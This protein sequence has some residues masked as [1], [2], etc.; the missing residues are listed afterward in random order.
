MD[1]TNLKQSASANK[2][3]TI[4]VSQLDKINAIPNKITDNILMDGLCQEDQLYLSTLMDEDSS[5]SEDDDHTNPSRRMSSA[6]S[7][8]AQSPMMM[9]NESRTKRLRRMRP[10]YAVTLSLED[11]SYIRP[12]WGL[13]KGVKRIK[14]KRRKEPLG[15][16]SKVTNREQSQETEATQDDEN[17]PQKP[18][19]DQKRLT[20]YHVF[21]VITVTFL[22]TLILLSYFIDLHRYK[23]HIFENRI[24]LDPLARTMEIFRSKQDIFLQED[25]SSFN[26]QRVLG[27]RFGQGIPAN[28]R[29]DHCSCEM[30]ER[31]ADKFNGLSY[32]TEKSTSSSNTTCFACLDWSMRANLQVLL[33]HEQQTKISPSV[34]SS[35]MDQS[36]LPKITC[37]EV[38]WQSYDSLTTPLVDCFNLHDEEQ[39]IGLGDI[40]TP[41]WPLNSA[42]FN[43]TSLVASLAREFGNELE[44][45]GA[46]S[47]EKED[48]LLL[49]ESGRGQQRGRFPSRNLIFGSH[50]NFTFF[51]S[52][53]FY[54]GDLKSDFQPSIWVTRSAGGSGKSGSQNGGE[55]S[56]AKRLCLSVRC[57]ERCG[58]SWVSENHVNKWKHRN[59]ILEYRICS[60]TNWRDLLERQMRS[61][62]IELATRFI[63]DSD[64][65]NSTVLSAMSQDQVS[66]NQMSSRL[67]MDGHSQSQASKV[68]AS[69]SSGNTAQQMGRSNQSSD[70]PTRDSER[71]D[72][73]PVQPNRRQQSNLEGIGLIERTIF[74]TSHEF[75]PT[76]DG[77]TLRQ[78]VDNIVKLGLKTS[79]ILLI[80]TRWQLYAGSLKLN[81]ALFPKA[82]LLFEILHNK[83]FKILLTIKPYIDTDIGIG[84]INALM[85][86]NRIFKATAHEQVKPHESLQPRQVFSSDTNGIHEEADNQASALEGLRITRRLDFFSFGKQIVNV[87]DKTSSRIPYLYPNKDSA[88]GYCVLVDLTED[89]NREWLISLIKRS[90]WLT[91]EADGIHFA[92]THPDA[93]QWEDQYREGFSKLIESLFY[94]ENLYTLPQWTGNFG[95][96]Q[97]APRPRTWLGL[98]ST[99]E[100]VLNLGHLGFALIHP[101]SVWGDFLWPN[102]TTGQTKEHDEKELITR[103]LQVSIFLPILQFKDLLPIEKHSLHD[104]VENLMKIRKV[105]VVP[106]L[107][108]HLPF[109]PL[110]GDAK[111]RRNQANWLL[112]DHHYNQQILPVIRHVWHGQVDSGGETIVRKQ[113]FVGSDILVAPIL[114]EGH[115]QRD[116]YLPNGFW[117]DELRQ[118]NI[119]GGKWLRNYPV[120]LNEVAWFTRARR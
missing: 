52:N 95:Y 83:G 66:A 48:R 69:M 37:Y 117:H 2:L 100:S 6:W 64:E 81:S 114:D 5:E 80:D 55:S 110:V 60:G 51:T 47:L 77:Q 111:S 71:M 89:R 109:S 78:F 70:P 85:E 1:H 33:L 86:S 67:L 46:M 108:K 4:D 39:W 93:M 73:T 41:Q 59:N 104:Q 107:L 119:R 61:K 32:A 87:V 98:Q 65:T 26:R 56:N 27:I 30:F 63:N 42:P 90:L 115:R 22:L 12:S 92:G 11:I 9:M 113:F 76:L 96:I 49:Y 53:G 58:K 94:R 54:L 3:S 34:Y 72:M 13:S 8:M 16:E 25:S 82:K 97:L 88:S 29:G 103:W 101:G 21:L 102:S 14:K 15:G 68:V 106:E 50:V 7:P 118:T 40:Q 44:N 116:I 36:L 24:K 43:E 23:K 10:S 31:E 28:L 20:A 19:V 84:Q 75:I 99:V 91:Q 62:S 35:V 112:N 120:E 17:E 57:T 79:P 45:V 105:H 18:G 74:A 38:K